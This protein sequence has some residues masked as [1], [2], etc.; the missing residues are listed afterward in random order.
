MFL[1]L[2]FG[3]WFEVEISGGLAV[4]SVYL[5]VGRKDWHILREGAKL[6]LDG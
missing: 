2:H 1:E 5:K 3:Q 4:S 6:S